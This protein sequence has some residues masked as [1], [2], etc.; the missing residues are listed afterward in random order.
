MSPSPST[1]PSRTCLRLAGA[2]G[3]AVALS[4]AVLPATGASAAMTAGAGPAAAPAAT[5]P[6]LS[7]VVNTRANHGQVQKAEQVVRASGGTVVQAW[8]QIGVVVVQSAVPDFRARVLGT[9]RA[10]GITSVGATRTAAV[11][12]VPAY[13][14][15]PAGTTRAGL[16]AEGTAYDVAQIHADAAH[17]RGA[18]GSPDVLVAILDSGVDATHEDLAANFDAKDSAGCT[19]NGKPDTARTAWLPTTSDHGTHVAGTIAA[20]D[21]G[22]GVVGVAPDTRISSVKVVDDDGFIYPEYAICGFVW[23]A[24][25]GA[26]V[27]NNSYYIDPWMYWCGSDPDQAA[28]KESVTRAVAYATGRG[29][30]SVAAAGNDYTDLANNTVDT[31]SPDDSTPEPRPLDASCLDLPTELPGVVT[32]ASTTST[33]TKST[34]SNYGLGVIDVAAPGS[35]IWSTTIGS[36]Y[37]VKSG[38]SMASPHVAGVAALLKSSHPRATPAQLLTLLRAQAQDTACGTDQPGSGAQP[39]QHCTGTAAYNA[40]FGDGIVDALAA[41]TR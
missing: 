37:G 26:D 32:V 15:A 16:P 6:L 24:E 41:A 27:T 23:A 4:L 22:K 12:P 17:A 9:T 31:S 36:T 19:A 39:T 40:F 33:G 38:T 35:S 18:K 5:G 25:H 14:P 2:A 34:F 8:E 30:L 21:N 11:K 28:V 1:V 10:S 13:A 3:A 7:Y 29:V 20:D